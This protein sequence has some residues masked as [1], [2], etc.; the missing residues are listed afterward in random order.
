MTWTI[1]PRSEGPGGLHYW[2]EGQGPALV[3]IHGVGL[4]AEAWGGVMPLLAPHFMVYAVDMPGHGAS[5]LNNTTTLVDY[6]ER[7]AAFIAAL[8]APVAVAGHSMGAFIAL[9]IASAHPE[10]LHSVAALNAVFERTED[11][12]Q[13]VQARATCLKDHGPSDPTPT[14]QRWFGAAPSGEHLAAAIACRT[15]LTDAHHDGYARAY[16]SLPTTMGRPARH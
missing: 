10:S 15:W 12:S 3:L 4:R 7:F 14:L 2:S 11:A 1:R 13:A 5:P 6:T 8:D 9:E 16:W